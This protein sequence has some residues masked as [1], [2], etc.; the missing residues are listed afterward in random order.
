MKGSEDEHGLGAM[1][2]L[3][4][5]DHAGVRKGVRL[6]L[7]SRSDW[8]VCAEAVDGLDAVE[9]AK[10]CRPDLVILDLSMPKMS[11]LEAVPLI[12]K[13]LPNSS[14][15][16][17]SQ[18]DPA[19]A[20]P[21]ALGAG[22]RGFVAKPDMA[23]DLLA[24]I[25][26]LAR[27]DGSKNGTSSAGLS[28]PDTSAALPPGLEFLIGAGEMGKLIREFDWS[29]TPL[30]PIASWPQILKTS[31]GL[32]LNSQ[33]PMWVGWGPE[34]TFLYNDAYIS[35][36]SLAK[37]PWALGRPAT[38]VWAEIWEVCGPLADKVFSRGEATFVDE[39]QLFMSRG[40][41]VEETYYSFSYSPIRDESGHVRGLFCPSAEVTP[42]VLNARRLRT[43][44]ELTAKSLVERTT[45]AACASAF[46]TLSKNVDDIPFALLYLIDRDG[47]NAFLEQGCGVNDSGGSVSPGRIALEGSSPG[48]LS[49]AI[50]EV[51]TSGQSRVTSV[52]HLEGL[53]EG[54]NRQPVSEALVLPVVSHEQKTV[55]VLVAGVSPTRRLDTEYRTF[56]ELVSS[57]IATCIANARSYEEERKRSESLAELD[58]A[59]TAFFSNVS[60]EFRTPLTLMLGPLDDVLSDAG[61][62]LPSE[63]TESLKVVHRNSLRLLKLVN[64][65]LDFSRIEAGRIEAVYQP[66][67]ISG[68]T[69]EL[70]SA[71]RSA[72]ERAGLEYVVECDR[73]AEPVFLDRD[74]WEKIVLN[75]LS[76]AFKFTMEGRV[77][78]ALKSLEDHV[79]LQ[80]SDT[81]IGVSKE[82][83]PRLFERFHRVEGAKGRTQEGTGIGLALVH[84][85]VKIH[86]GTLEVTSEEGVGSTFT[87]TLPKGDNHLPQERI[88]ATKRPASSAIRADS[89]VEEAVRWLPEQ[90]EAGAEAVTPTSL[91]SMIPETWG[92]ISEGELIVV[93]DDNADMRDYLRR[94][95][96]ERYRVHTVSNGE[97]AVKAA[98]D[99]NADLVLTDVMMPGL[100]GFGVLRS[101]RS[102]PKTQAKPVILLSA[103]AGEESRVEGLQAGADDYLVKPFAARELLARVSAHLKMARVR[104]EAAEVERRLRAEAELERSRF[105]ESFTRAP[106]A[107]ALLSGPEHRF[108]FVNSAYL[109]SARRDSADQLLNKTIREVF[110]ELEGQGLHEILDQIYQSG[111][112]FVARERPVTFKRNGKEEI[113]YMNFSYHPMRNVAGEVEG[114]LVHSVEVTEQV[115]ARNQLEARVK[116]RTF[117]LEDAEERL[118]ALNSRLLR[119]QDDERRRLARELHDSAG[120]ILAALSMSLIPLEQELSHQ[121]QELTKLAT[122]SIALVDELSKELRTMSHLLHPPLLDEAGLKSALRWYVEGFAERSGVQVDLQLD[123]D[124][125]RLSQEFE[126]TIFRIVQ[127]S[128]TNIHRHSGSKSAALRIEHRLGNTRVEIR[129]EGRGIAQFDYSKNRPLKV[130]VGIQGMQ[131]RVR[132][133]RGEFEIKSGKSGTTVVVV[134]PESSSAPAVSQPM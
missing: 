28:S 44:S 10:S 3:I 82:E 103:R 41:F 54:P 132:Q 67:Y 55:G 69:T 123:G 21:L 45:G 126:T 104:A 133:L 70:A 108:T 112:T 92:R 87:V 56:F 74:M 25:D 52:K 31:V 27:R 60:H 86:H 102:D 40:D 8:V 20:R 101:L 96:K 120:Q 79:Q 109:E 22:A 51:A 85:L 35:V 89:F 124:F 5:D 91:D 68:L 15:L 7:S 125:P 110:P 63:T 93:A 4:A 57:Q 11:G 76:N 100:D 1:R 33:H 117:E 81:G 107:M 73:V 129:D 18:H 130:G 13:E 78:V 116:E 80:I 59:K 114:I 75:L 77:S 46:S 66:T 131:E 72:M 37:H 134:L 88:W 98:R 43:L 23:R 34:T 24:E 83:I 19:H 65:L 118:R 47:K 115:I 95:L 90:S 49:Q 122:S 2:I 6:L 50:A 105:R 39:V 71:F 127:E 61:N 119:A 16:I 99:L 53:P 94:L 64:S 42:K 30:G 14:I 9:K 38:E 48:A 121:N 58:R 36:L 106:A 97:E 128:L 29:K 17:L 111:E 84:E 62:A 12:R 113:T 26:G 32:I